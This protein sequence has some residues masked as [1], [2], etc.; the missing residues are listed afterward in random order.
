MADSLSSSRY[1]T[2]AEQFKHVESMMNLTTKIRPSRDLK[3]TYQNRRE[4]KDSCFAIH[5]KPDEPLPQ[6]V[7]DAVTPL[8][9][10]SLQQQHA[11]DLELL[12]DVIVASLTPVPE[13]SLP[14]VPLPSDYNKVRNVYDDVQAFDPVM[15]DYSDI[16]ELQDGLN[17]IFWNGK[18]YPLLLGTH[19]KF[20]PDCTRTYRFR[21]KLGD[22]IFHYN[23]IMYNFMIEK[24]YADE[25]AATNSFI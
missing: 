7:R 3:S 21:L 1:K 4:F 14:R 22:N 13:S 17:L 16:Q 18:T 10:S 8:A 25:M 9:P 15:V 20:D 5:M 11:G 12:H 6:S 19:G 2:K 23:D 24:R